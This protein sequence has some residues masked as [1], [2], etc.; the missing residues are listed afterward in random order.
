MMYA[1][2]RSL[3]PK[4]SAKTSF[5]RLN[6]YRNKFTLIIP[7]LHSQNYH[8]HQGINAY[9]LQHMYLHHPFWQ[10]HNKVHV[11]KLSLL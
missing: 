11:R 3:L 7:V 10:F 4:P 5:V 8:T 9:N 1:Y 2:S 6:K